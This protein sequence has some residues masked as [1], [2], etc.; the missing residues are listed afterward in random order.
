MATDTEKDIAYYLEHPEEVDPTNTELVQKLLA[1]AGESAGADVKVGVDEDAAK[2]EADAKAA[3]D[4]A[5]AEAEKKAGAAKPGGAKGKEEDE[6]RLPIAARDGKHVMPFTVLEKSREATA[7]AETAL[8]EAM[9]ANVALVNRVKALE[10]GKADPGAKTEKTLDELEEALATARE[11]APWSVP[12]F[13]KLVARIR[14]SENR[15]AQLTQDALDTD[16]VEAERLVRDANAAIA[17]NAT[18]LLWK[19]EAP[20]L[21]EEAVRFDKYI[22]KTPEEAQHFYNEDG[23]V[24]FEARFERVVA[25]VKAAHDGEDVPLPKPIESSEKP[26]A[27]KAAPDPE[28]VKAAAREKLKSAKQDAAVTTLSDLP[29]GAPAAQSETEAIESMSTAALGTQLMGMSP[30]KLQS[31]L[32][33]NA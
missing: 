10:S 6:E 3:E 27:A 28:Q 7:A 23:S 29:G 8:H 5:K 24:D 9:Q 1:A 4:A 19:A 32:A 31:W 17:G 2:K 14:E 22:R 25:L 33:R 15:V 26:G 30:E 11:E 18:L 13:E 20:E 12:V 16:Q 21:F